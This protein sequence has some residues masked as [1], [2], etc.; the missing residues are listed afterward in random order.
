MMIWLA[1]VFTAWAL[2][3]GLAQAQLA[4]PALTG[5]VVDSVGVLQDGPRQALEA[6]LAAFEQTKG[7]QVVV[8]VVPTTQPE[9]I[10]SYA[11]RVGNTWKIGR[12]AVGDGVLLIAAVNDRKLR[13]EVAKTL[14][15]AIPDLAA[16][17]IIDQS[18][19]PYFRQGDYA[20]G[21]NVGTDQI[22]ALIKGEALPEPPLRQGARDSGKAGFDWTEFAVF[23]FFAVPVLGTVVKNIFGSRLGSLLAG[24]FA[25]GMA[26]WLT[27]SLLIA[28]AAGVAGLLFTL[29]SN[30][31]PPRRNGYGGGFGSGN[32]GGHGGGFGGGGFSSGGGGD[33]GGGGA[34]GGW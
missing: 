31:A 12:K 30:S 7:S 29:L 15:G 25:G 21:L 24:A 19:T 28:G 13:I 1:R 16:K 34:S 32:G 9:D 5:H 3:L 10:A 11:N 33:F 22:M 27:T 2:F 26:F 6:K 23:M 20:A 4:V 18:I 14:E 8:L 17:R